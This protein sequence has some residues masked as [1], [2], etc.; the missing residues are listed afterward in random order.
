M[1]AGAFLRLLYAAVRDEWPEA[2]SSVSSA[3]QSRV[4]E[5]LSQYLLVRAA[6][7]FLVGVFA[8]VTADRLHVSA[9]LAV[10]VMVLVEIFRSNG[11]ALAGL[12]LRGG[13]VQRSGSLIAYHLAVVVLVAA[14][15]LLA[16]SAAPGWRALSP[17]RASCL[18]PSGRACSRR[19]S[20]SPRDAW[21]P[22][23]ST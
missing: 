22:S 23:R 12:V 21:S 17:P 11:T 15:G 16:S 10:S 13:S 14:T 8:T 5:R 20:A 1:L 19:S 7:V 6:P 18:R 4:R 3:L 9:G 2:Y